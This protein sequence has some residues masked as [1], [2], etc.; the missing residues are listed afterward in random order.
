VICCC[1]ISYR[2]ISFKIGSRAP[3]RALGALCKKCFVAVASARK[4]SATASASRQLI[5]TTFTEPL[6]SVEI[7]IVFSTLLGLAKL[8]VDDQLH[9]T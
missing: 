2:K 8:M 7:L 4:I 1:K 9:K 5:E 3:E 6:H